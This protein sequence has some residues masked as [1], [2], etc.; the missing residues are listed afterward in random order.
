MFVYGDCIP[1]LV[2]GIGRRPHGGG[3]KE[4]G[5]IH[6]VLPGPHPMRDNEN[7]DIRVIGI[8][9]ILPIAGTAKPLAPGC[10]AAATMGLKLVWG[11][12]L[13]VYHSVVANLAATLSAAG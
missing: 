1:A 3:N 10:I 4:Y 7:I 6:L 12:V 2:L 9:V 5:S 11:P 8:S 13:M